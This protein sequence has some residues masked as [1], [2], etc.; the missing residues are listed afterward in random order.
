MVI[1][2]NTGPRNFEASRVAPKLWVG[3]YP[4]EG[5][6]MLRRAQE[7]G[8]DR[9][10]RVA[11]ELPHEYPL[12]DRELDADGALVALK[13]AAEVA[14]EL[15][16]G[17]RVLVTCQAGINRS[18]L[19]AGLAMVMRFGWSGREAVARIRRARRPADGSQALRN[20]SFAYFLAS[21][22]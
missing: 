12:D 16:A 3:S 6:E 7:V 19:V 22:R 18:A 5:P 15:K 14:R 4:G 9:V 20:K 10:I 17:R 2:P 21:Y 8:F 13:A 11:M 1:E